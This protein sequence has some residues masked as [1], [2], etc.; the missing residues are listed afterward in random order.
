M[1]KATILILGGY[2]SAGR[3]VS[4]L[5]LQATPVKKVMIAGR[6]EAKAQQQSEALAAEFGADR[7]S[8]L[9]VDADDRIGLGQALA[10]V[11]L[12]IVCLAYRGNQAANVLQ[13]VLDHGIHYIDLSPTA[14]KQTV[15]RPL[16]ERL[17]AHDCIVLTEAGIFD[18]S[19]P[20]SLFAGYGQAE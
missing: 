5:L 15:L 6:N 2:G 19:G 8:P 16:A 4:R 13:A 9:V 1:D 14:Q 17:A 3:P 20:L 11:D 10:Q 7:V 18:E 12:V